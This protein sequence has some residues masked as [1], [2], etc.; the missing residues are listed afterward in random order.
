MGLKSGMKDDEN[1]PP[2]I[3]PTRNFF[4]YSPADLKLFKA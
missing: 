2:P 1:W 3:T 4:T